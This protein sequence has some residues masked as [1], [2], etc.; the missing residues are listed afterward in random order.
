MLTLYRPGTG[1]L[2]RAPAGA[3]ALVILAAVLTVSLLPST[4]PFAAIALGSALVAYLVTGFGVAVLARQLVGLRWV[5]LITLGAQLIFLPT[6]PAVA[7]TSRVVGAVLIASL[8]VLST[9]VVDLLDAFERGLGPLRRVGIDP[10][11]VSL[12]LAI[13]MTTIPVLTRVATSIREAQRARGAGRGIR[14]F[15]IPFLVL[16]LKHADDLGDALTA[17]GA[18]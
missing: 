5:I 15:I 3:K 11:R 2:H 1:W 13:T 12:V 16:S 14:S 6:E 7:N 18:A 8:L 4:Y 17:R 10:A 9:R